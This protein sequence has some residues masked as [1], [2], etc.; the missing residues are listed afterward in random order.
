[1]KTNL[2]LVRNGMLV[3]LFLCFAFNSNAQ[4]INQAK[5]NITNFQVVKEKN[6]VVIK[7][8]TDKTSQHK[9]F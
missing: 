3:V 7:W 1:M 9:L 4:K 2:L 5:I 6:K 8:S